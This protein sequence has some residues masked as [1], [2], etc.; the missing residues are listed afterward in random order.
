MFA[1]LR[2]TVIEQSEEL[3]TLLISLLGPDRVY[4]FELGHTVHSCSKQLHCWR[5]R[6]KQR[7]PAELPKV[8]FFGTKTLLLR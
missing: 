5:Q 8:A 4:L 7:N 6:E 2:E 1:T 3:C